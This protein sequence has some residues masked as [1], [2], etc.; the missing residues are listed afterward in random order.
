M[1]AYAVYYSAYNN[2]SC[3]VIFA[4]NPL[5]ARWLLEDKLARNNLEVTGLE[6]IEELDLNTPRCYTSED[7]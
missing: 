5:V 4:P 2:E 3:I 7:N 1:K 6:I